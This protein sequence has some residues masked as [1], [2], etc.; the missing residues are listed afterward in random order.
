MSCTKFRNIYPLFL[1]LIL[2]IILL[3]LPLEPQLSLMLM[4]SARF[5]RLYSF[6]SKVYFLFFRINHFFDL[7]INPFT[8]TDFSLNHIRYDFKPRQWLFYLINYNFQLYNFHLVL[9]R[10]FF[11]AVIFC[12]FI[13][14]QYIFLYIIKHIYIGCFKILVC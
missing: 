1:N 10:F 9:Y 13:H 8:F 6:H 2:F 3:L 11:S 7:L 14:K 5:L 12:I 4:L